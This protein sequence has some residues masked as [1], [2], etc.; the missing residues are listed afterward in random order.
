MVV[1]INIFLRKKTTRF[2]A[3][4]RESAMSGWLPKPHTLRWG[5]W[6]SWSGDQTGN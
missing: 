5:W 2:A 1:E 3:T 6:E 4:Q